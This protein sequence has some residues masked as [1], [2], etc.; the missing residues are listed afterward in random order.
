MRDFLSHP[1]GMISVT[2]GTVSLAIWAAVI[3][4]ATGLGL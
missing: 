1:L 4:K 3:V 2:C